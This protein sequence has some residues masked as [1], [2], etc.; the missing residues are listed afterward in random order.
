MRRSPVSWPEFQQ[1]FPLVCRCLEQAKLHQRVG[2][3][4]LLVGDDSE[5]LYGFA[6]AWAQIAACRQTA[7]SGIACGQCR[8]CQ[9]FQD[10]TYNDCLEIAPQ[11]KSR[12]I[13]IEA[14]RNFMLQLS[15]KARPD[16]LKIG[17]IQAAECLGPEAQ[18][19]FLKTLEE[20]PPQTLLLLLTANAR[21][22]L[23]T[24]RSRCQTL[25]LLR[26]RRCYPDTVTELLLP[27]LARLQRQAGVKIA[28]EA[29]AGIGAAFKQLHHEA[30][31]FVAE[32]WDPRWENTAA[33]N[34]KL[35]RE[36]TELRE[37]KI[38]SE[39]I[40]LREEFI[41][42][43]QSWFQQRY[44]IAR[45]VGPEL[46]PVPEFLLCAEQIL[47]YPPSPDE[48]DQD[49]RHLAEF[50]KCLKAN[51][52]ESLALDTLCLKLCEKTPSSPSR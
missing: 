5:Y 13:T 8:P 51:V 31:K 44:L 33:D 28:L 11:S 4:Y 16:R 12:I 14:I 42:A 18:N 40:R 7:P 20:P 21:L 10:R 2:Q 6:R 22:L 27:I 9:L 35:I 37:Q 15:L 36:L 32:N 45:G 38:E 29:S 39:Y 41:E 43:M 25:L 17:L 52:E 48:A 46:L 47:R 34:K 19:A 3:A 1:D 30:E 24:I 23:P 26:N 49:I 50:A